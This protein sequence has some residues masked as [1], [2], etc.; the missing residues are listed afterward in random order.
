MP[1]KLA[2]SV[3]HRFVALAAPFTVTKDTEKLIDEVVDLV[4][5]WWLWVKQ[6]Q[7]KLTKAFVF[8]DRYLG[9][10]KE[11]TRQ[12][13]EVLSTQLDLLEKAGKSLSAL[14]NRAQHSRTKV[15]TVE[16]D[17]DLQFELLLGLKELDKDEAL[18]APREALEACL[19]KG[20]EY[21]RTTGVLDTL[22]NSFSR[23]IGSVSRL[24]KLLQNA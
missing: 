14:L 18:K 22:T 10:D 23:F 21:N 11:E 2:Q 24:E 15:K 17:K 9:N 7:K 16:D 20:F 6:Y 3:V 4:F 1:D 19:K 5:E 8:V 12:V 13:K